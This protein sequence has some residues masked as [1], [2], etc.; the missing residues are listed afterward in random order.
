MM[1]WL[2]FYPRPFPP[3]RL[4]VVSSLPTLNLEAVPLRDECYAGS[5]FG[6]VGGGDR[7]SLR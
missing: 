7:T 5:C 6:V 4:C 2:S 1:A 3:P